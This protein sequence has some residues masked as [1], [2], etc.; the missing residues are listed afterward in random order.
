MTIG[1]TDKTDT[2]ASW[3]N[4]GNCVDWFAPGVGITS[5]WYT[6]PTATN[7]ISG[8]SMATPH[9]TGVAALYLESHSGD[10]PQQVRDALGRIGDGTFGTCIVDGGPI[11]E[12]RLKAL[13][14]TPY[15][16]KHATRLE[17]AALEKTPTL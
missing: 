7:T 11:E 9:T 13:P 12:E 3:S 6:S 8:T 1:A 14:W 5:A 10:T 17:A 16:M 15:C 4:Y 2:K